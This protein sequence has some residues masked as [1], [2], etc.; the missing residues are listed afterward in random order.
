MTIATNV[1][2]A[3]RDYVCVECHKLITKGSRYT[4]MFGMADS[5]D[6]PYRIKVCRDCKPVREDKVNG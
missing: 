1:F 4:S 5:G 6:R 3:R 2:K